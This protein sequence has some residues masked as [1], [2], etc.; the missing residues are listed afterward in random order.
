MRDELLL[1]L[2]DGLFLTSCE[3]WSEPDQLG[4][5]KEHWV[6]NTTPKDMALQ[7]STHPMLNRHR[8]NFFTIGIVC[9]R[10]NYHRLPSALSPIGI[11]FHRHR[12]SSAPSNKITIGNHWHRQKNAAI[13]SHRHRV[14]SVRLALARIIGHCIGSDRLPSSGIAIVRHRQ[15][16]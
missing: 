9:H 3:H 4:E 15:I 14:A 2:W 7:M 12:V 13:V 8:H 10:D 5:G 1:R 6:T 16:L 11:V